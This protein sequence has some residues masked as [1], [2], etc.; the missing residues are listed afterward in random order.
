MWLLLIVVAVVMFLVTAF[1]LEVVA[2]IKKW[3]T[4]PSMIMNSTA[5]RHLQDTACQRV[6]HWHSV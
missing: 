1:I 4:R 6:P 3:E 2:L 5:T